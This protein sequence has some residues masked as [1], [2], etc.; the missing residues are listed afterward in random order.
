MVTR[1]AVLRA[2]LVAAGVGGVGFTIF[3][4][5]SDPTG[6]REQD[7]IGLIPYDRRPVMP[8]ISGKLMDA[9]TFTLADWHGQPVVINWWGRRGA[10]PV[11]LRP[12]T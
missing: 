6:A 8:P 4:W 9:T 11:A 2:T 1:R 7:L 5:A 3:S 10:D 12:L